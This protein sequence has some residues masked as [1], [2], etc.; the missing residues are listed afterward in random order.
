MVTRIL[1]TP[2]LTCNAAYPWADAILCDD[3]NWKLIMDIAGLYAWRD[4]LQVFVCP[5]PIEGGNPACLT[6]LQHIWEVEYQF[7]QEH[8][9]IVPYKAH[10]ST[11]LLDNLRDFLGS[12]HP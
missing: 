2:E 6:V 10:T 9:E 1:C 11:T 3:T 8:Y 4:P 12:V 7:T 5:I